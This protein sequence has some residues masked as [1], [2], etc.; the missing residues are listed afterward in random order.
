MAK[1]PSRL[2]LR[3]LATNRASRH[4]AGYLFLALLPATA[5]CASVFRKYPAADNEAALRAALA[6]TS[7]DPGG[8]PSWTPWHAMTAWSSCAPDRDGVVMCAIPKAGSS[9]I[10]S[11]G[12][13]ALTIAE[14]SKALA[15]PSTYR[16]ALVRDPLARFVSWYED[17]VK[18]R[19][20]GPGFY[21]SALHISN[22]S[23]RHSMHAYAAALAREGVGTMEPHLRSQAHHC[24]LHLL[25]FDLVH[26]LEDVGSLPARVTLALNVTDLQSLP[27]KNA[28]DQRSALTRHSLSPQATCYD[29]SLRQ[30]VRTAYAEDYIWIGRHGVEY[31]GPTAQACGRVRAGVEGV[32]VS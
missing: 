21:N 7:Y 12:A 15:Q 30:L 8:R 17:K 13:H 32:E 24:A 4:P 3:R 19:I 29:D 31:T 10:K 1:T 9:S 27:T 23:V 2:M 6:S 14:V 26:P 25:K 20:P 22:D 5:F 28:H 16:V 18:G 11:M